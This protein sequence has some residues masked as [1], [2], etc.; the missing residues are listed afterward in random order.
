MIRF[1]GVFAPNSAWRAV[2]VPPPGNGAPAA[3][4]A[5][6]PDACTAASITTTE[7]TTTGIVGAR[8]QE[9]DDKTAPPRGTVANET[10]V[11]DETGALS[12]NAWRIDWATLLK[13][14]YDIDVLACPCG[15][16]I[17][18]AAL[19][20]DPEQA[21]ELLERLGLPSAPPPLPRA[22]SPDAA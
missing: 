14:T 20:T 19:V 22:R 4:P 5:P 18:I 15:G 3:D 1:H 11:A 9:A 8:K 21:R 6:P 17:K 2:C 12:Q 10:Q 13:R 16:R 7:G